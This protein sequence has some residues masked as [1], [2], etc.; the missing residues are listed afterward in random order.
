M[1]ACLG[2]PLSTPAP[3]WWKYQG[4]KGTG[5]WV[6][7][8]RMGGLISCHLRQT[9]LTGP[10]LPRSW[11]PTRVLQASGAKWIGLRWDLDLL[12]FLSP[13]NSFLS[14]RAFK[15]GYLWS[16]DRITAYFQG[17]R[18]VGGGVFTLRIASPRK[19][20]F[21][22]LIAFGPKERKISHGVERFWEECVGGQRRAR[23]RMAGAQSWRNTSSFT[24]G[25]RWETAWGGRGLSS[26]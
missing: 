3:L 12:T 4:T 19:F 17:I 18:T 11:D 1:W 20:S 8:V 13:F 22:A 7:Y 23:G 6:I 2:N 10:H 14:G 21:W 9:S 25:G 15:W 24:V 26:C 5:G 16:E